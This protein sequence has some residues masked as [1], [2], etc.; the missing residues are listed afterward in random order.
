ML[1]NKHTK[2]TAKV[3]RVDA[4]G[5]HVLSHPLDH[6]YRY[7]PQ[8]IAD[9]WSLHEQ[10]AVGAAATAAELVA[11]RDCAEE[12]KIFAIAYRSHPLRNPEDKLDAALARYDEMSSQNVKDQTTAKTKL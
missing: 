3:L 4:N 11:W 9:H 8:M 10:A 12:L 2:R 1:I 5:D 6:S 7:D